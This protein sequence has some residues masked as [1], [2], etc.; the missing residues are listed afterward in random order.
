MDTI[1]HVAISIVSGFPFAIGTK[2]QNTF[3]GG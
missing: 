3:S 2:I 1:E